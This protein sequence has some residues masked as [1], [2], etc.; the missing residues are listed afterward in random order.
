VNIGFLEQVYLRGLE[1]IVGDRLLGRAL[2][3]EGSP[4]ITA[5]EDY[6]EAKHIAEQLFFK[7][8]GWGL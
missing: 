2:D 6:F 8:K 7:M 5:L 3:Y 4:S 1:G